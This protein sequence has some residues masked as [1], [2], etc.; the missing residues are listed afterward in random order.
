MIIDEWRFVIGVEV[1]RWVNSAKFERFWVCAFDLE[2]W[3]RNDDFQQ[4]CY[5]WISER[6]IWPG[7][8]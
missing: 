1:H 6:R 2:N 7:N 3:W 4:V 5:D 8:I